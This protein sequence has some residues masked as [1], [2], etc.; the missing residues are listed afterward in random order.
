MVALALEDVSASFGGTPVLG[1]LSI[2]VAT[3]EKVALVGKSGAGKSTLLSL[4]FEDA[5]VPVSYVPQA[6]GLVDTLSVFHNVFMGRLSENPTWYN[7]ANLVYPFQRERQAIAPILDR[8]GLSEKRRAAAG[9]LSGGQRQRTAVARAVYQNARLLLADEPVSALDGPLAHVVMQTLTET[10]DTTV[11]ALH[12]VELALQYCDRIVGIKGG[13]IV[14][15]QA[16]SRLSADDLAP[17]YR[18]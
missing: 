7:L 9:E 10:Y 15:D 4:M 16:S 2:T 17:L 1:P 3:G 8:L 12:D 13:V 14:L 5:R 11:I 6:L 18:D